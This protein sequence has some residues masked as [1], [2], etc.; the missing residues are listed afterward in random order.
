L[1]PQ[2]KNRDDA[3]SFH[4]R[5]SILPPTEKGRFHVQKIVKAAFFVA[6]KCVSP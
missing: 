4:R 5:S 6:R 3:G 1:F 2:N